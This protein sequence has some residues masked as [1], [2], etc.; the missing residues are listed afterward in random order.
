M[1]HNLGVVRHQARPPPSPSATKPVHHQARPPPSPS[2][3]KPEGRKMIAHGASR[4]EHIGRPPSP[5][6]GRKS[7]PHNSASLLLHVVFSTKDRA[8]DLS[9]ELAARLFPYM[10]GI[11]RERKGVRL[12]IHGPADHV[13]L[14]VY[15]VAT[16]SIA[17]LLRVVKTNSSRSVHEQFPEHKRFGWQAGY[18]A[19]TVSGS[20]AADVTDYIAAQQEHH[21]RVS[22]TRGIPDI[23]EEAWHST[24]CARPLGLR[25]A[26][27]PV[28]GLAI[29]D[30]LFHTA[31]AVGWYLSPC[32]LEKCRNSRARPPGLSFRMPGRT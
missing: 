10:A 15:V 17:D 9:P 8:S 27:R 30:T 6:T 32:E 21:R 23:P 22:F 16:E 31:H 11:V 28:P 18:G 29:P 20:R 3:T 12:I 2:A 19:F 1:V 14:L 5:G 13:H 7:M 24:R 25:P 26:F 4:W